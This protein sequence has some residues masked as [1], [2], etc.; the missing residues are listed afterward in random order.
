MC[1]KI[2]FGCQLAK[3]KDSLEFIVWRFQLGPFILLE[4]ELFGTLKQAGQ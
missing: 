2:A 3:G 4:N 1:A